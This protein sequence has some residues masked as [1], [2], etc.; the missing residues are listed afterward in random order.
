MNFKSVYL[1]NRGFIEK[2]LNNFVES[3]G[4]FGIFGFKFREPFYLLPFIKVYFFNI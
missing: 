3:I 4:Q 1:N 2:T